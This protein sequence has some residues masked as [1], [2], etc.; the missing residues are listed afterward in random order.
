MRL[1][2]IYKLLSYRAGT[3]GEQEDQA[4]H[5]IEW[6]KNKT[7][8][9]ARWKPISHQESNED[10]SQQITRLSCKMRYNENFNSI[11]IT[12]FQ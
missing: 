7:S 3:A 11:C 6:V 8:A 10:V 4:E 9:R 5:D 12:F 1:W 2:Y